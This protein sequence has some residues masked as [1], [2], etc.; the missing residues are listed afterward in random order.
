MKDYIGMIGFILCVTLVLMFAGFVSMQIQAE[1]PIDNPPK[2]PPPPE[3]QCW[4]VE[5]CPTLI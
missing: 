2:N 4:Y 5:E 1:T 3:D